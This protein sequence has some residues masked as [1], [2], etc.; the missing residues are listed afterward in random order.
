M[1]K[2]EPVLVFE[3]PPPIR[4]P[5]DPR[6]AVVLIPCLVVRRF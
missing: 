2:P 1:G 6:E 3:Y 4:D 5:F